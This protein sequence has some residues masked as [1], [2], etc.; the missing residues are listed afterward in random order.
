MI[1]NVEYA[2]PL[3]EQTGN[4]A[5][6]VETHSSIGRPSAIIVDIILDVSVERILAFTPLPRPSART[7]TVE[8][9]FSSTISTWSPQSCSPTWLILFQPISAHKSFIL[10]RLL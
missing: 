6:I 2:T 8:F 9:S 5:A 1:V 7:I 10:Y 3:T 4:V